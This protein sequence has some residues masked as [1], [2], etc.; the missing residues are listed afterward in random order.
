MLDN[1]SY[2]RHAQVMA[3]AAR[4]AMTWLGLPTYSPHRN[5]IE[6]IGKLVQADEL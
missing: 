1:A 5:L 3:E 6:R 4:L 2:Q